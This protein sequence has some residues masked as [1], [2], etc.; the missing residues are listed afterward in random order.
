MKESE[1]C[2]DYEIDDMTGPPVQVRQ[3]VENDV[4]LQKQINYWDSAS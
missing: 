1:T 2:M 3:F 4:S